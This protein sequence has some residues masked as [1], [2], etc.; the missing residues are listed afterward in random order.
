MKDQET[1]GLVMLVLLSC[2]AG[3]AFGIM[4]GGLL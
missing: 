4:L 3:L 2:M 1:V